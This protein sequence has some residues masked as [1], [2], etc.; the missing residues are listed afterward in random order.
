MRRR[1]FL[2]AP[3]LAGASFHMSAQQ[4]PSQA[5]L[6]LSC[7]YLRN[8]PDQQMQRVSD[9]LERIWMPA[10][11]RAGSGPVGIFASLIAPHSPFVMSLTSFPS[12][13]AMESAWQKMESDKEMLKLLEAWYEKPGLPYQR[14]ESWLLRGFDS[15]PNIEV[16]PA[17]PDKSA[18]VFELR[19]YE[20]NHGGTLRRK[21]K[22]FDDGEIAIFRRIGLRPVFFGR[23]L[24][25][26]NM[27]NLTYMLAF[28]SLAHREQA[29]RAFL[30]DPQWHKLRSTPGLSDAEIVSNISSMILRPLPFSDIR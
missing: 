28:D 3:A 17:K 12:L 2:S 30:D 7:Y 10:I 15:V 11:K 24:V 6:E 16:P 8:S 23:T 29:W 1:Q 5:I 14:V 27:P 22:M 4:T 20:S 25:G 21:I 9:A 26:G 13:A 18:R 19:T